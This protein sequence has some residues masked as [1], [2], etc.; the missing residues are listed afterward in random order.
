VELAAAAFGGAPTEDAAL[1][2]HR[3]LA[4][5]AR[6]AAEIGLRVRAGGG[7][8]GSAR[9]AR[10]AEIPE[11]EQIRVGPALLAGAFYEGIGASVGALRRAIDRGALRGERGRAEA[12]TRERTS[13]EEE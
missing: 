13:E 7:A 3:R 5:A 2:A 9:V 8:G 11:V 1:E 6:A 4:A 12:P 10:L